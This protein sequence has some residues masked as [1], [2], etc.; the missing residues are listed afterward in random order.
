MTPL[1]THH[2]NRHRDVGYS[3]EE[4]EMAGSRPVHGS[5]V[6]LNITA[7]VLRACPLPDHLY[8][9]SG[10][11]RQLRGSASLQ[12]ASTTHPKQ[13]QT[14]VDVG[15]ICVAWCIVMKQSGWAE[16]R[17]CA[18]GGGGISLQTLRP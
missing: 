18:W 3:A 8:S 9:K 7:P 1:T 2:P 6:L 4:G 16:R 14:P 13:A 15:H 11:A 10:L 5:Q 17:V 12:A